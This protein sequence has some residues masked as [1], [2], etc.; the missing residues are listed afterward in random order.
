[1][2]PA[3]RVAGGHDVGVPVETEASRRTLRAPARE[4]VRHAV[5]VD[6]VTVESR[7]VQKPRQEGEDA[8]LAGRDGGAADQIGRKDNGI[9]G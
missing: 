9:D 1:M 2:R 5:A 6:A 3:G 7:L 4:Q 8:A